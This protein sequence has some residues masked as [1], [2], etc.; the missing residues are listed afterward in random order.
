MKK[1]LKL[2]FSLLVLSILCASCE[3]EK[4][5][6]EVMFWYNTWGTNATIY[7]DGESGMITSY[8]PDYNPA[9]GAL[10]T[11]TFTLQEGTYS[12]T[13]SSSFNTWE[14]QVKVSPN[15]CLKMLLQ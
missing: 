10:G 7:I 13:A 2:I 9:C 5:D 1:N 14:G 6:G 3:K 15:G 4:L 11:A 8:Y 12:Y